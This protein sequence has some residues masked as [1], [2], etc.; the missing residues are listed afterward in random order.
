MSRQQMKVFIAGH[1]DLLTNISFDFYGNRM[2][3]S[4]A[5][6]TVKVFERVDGNWELVDSWRAHEA[7]VVCTSWAGPE[8]SQILASASHDCVVKIWEED[9]AELAKSGKRWKKRCT[10]QDYKAPLYDLK[11]SPNQNGLKMASIAADGILRVHEALDPN[12]ITAWTQVTELSLLNNPVARQLQSSFALDWCPSVLL[13]DYLVICILE[14]AFVY[15]RDASGKYTKVC[16]LTQHTGLIRDVAWAPSM[17]RSYQLVATACKDGYLRVFRLW[18]QKG[19]QVDLEH[20]YNAHAGEVWRVSW[21][22]T[23]TILSSAGD[24]GKI[25]FWKSMGRGRFQC[26]AVIGANNRNSEIKDA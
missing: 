14:D 26:M 17:G 7:P 2:A 23:G 16:E 20:E 13:Q 8:Y 10:I 21:N 19:W 5:D 9:T 1:K 11:F 18:P 3:T 12:N 15:R 25:K 22:V 4:G 24:D 6:H